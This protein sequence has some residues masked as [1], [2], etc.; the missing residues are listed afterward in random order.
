MWRPV[1]RERRRRHRIRLDESTET[2]GAAILRRRRRRPVSDCRFS[3][4]ASGTH[5]RHS[6]AATQ[7]F[8]GPVYSAAVGISFLAA[9]SVRHALLA[10]DT[11]ERK[12]HAQAQYPMARS[13]GQLYACSAGRLIVVPTQKGRFDYTL[14]FVALNAAVVKSRCIFTNFLTCSTMPQQ[15][16]RVASSQYTAHSTT[17]I[18]VV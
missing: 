11:L 9:C 10:S 5:T 15:Q 16:L 8:H 18:V 12:A 2:V 6:A 14:A 13:E 3:S 1:S 17:N 7:T 4:T